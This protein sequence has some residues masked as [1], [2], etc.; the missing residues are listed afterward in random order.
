MVDLEPG[1]ILVRLALELDIA[2]ELSNLVKEVDTNLIMRC[3]LLEKFGLFQQTSPYHTDIV[4]FIT[5]S[6]YR[7]NRK[8][9][10]LLALYSDDERF[11]MERIILRQVREMADT[12]IKVKKGLIK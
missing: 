3:L 4:T 9:E 1:Y 5:A 6:K 12:I 11:S 2:S 8:N 7:F 10:V